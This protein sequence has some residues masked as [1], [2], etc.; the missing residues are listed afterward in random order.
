M[1]DTISS[2][3]LSEIDRIVFIS[4]ECDSWLTDQGSFLFSMRIRIYAQREL[5]SAERDISSVFIANIDRYE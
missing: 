3:M 2:N 5:K 1:R 4:D